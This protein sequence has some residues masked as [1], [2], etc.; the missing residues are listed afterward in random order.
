M[1]RHVKVETIITQEPF[2]C[3]VCGYLNGSLEYR[4]ETND[5]W[6]VMQMVDEVHSMVRQD[7]GGP[8]QRQ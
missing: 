4:L 6:R 8:S 1:S 2:K 7:L 5:P 3:V